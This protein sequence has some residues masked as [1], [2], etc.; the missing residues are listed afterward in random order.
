MNS[1]TLFKHDVANQFAVNFDTQVFA[2]LKAAFK[3]S[4][5][6]YQAAN[7]FETFC[8]YKAGCRVG[9]G[10]VCAHGYCP[11]QSC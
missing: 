6:T 7:G 8:W 2:A 3:H 10:V 9:C 11:F 1:T 4:A 5:L